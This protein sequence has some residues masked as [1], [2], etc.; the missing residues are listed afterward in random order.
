MQE[1][2]HRSTGRKHSVIRVRFIGILGFRR[3]TRWSKPFT[4][5]VH[6]IERSLGAGR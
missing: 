6:R 3:R 4:V 5:Q 2:Q 1:L